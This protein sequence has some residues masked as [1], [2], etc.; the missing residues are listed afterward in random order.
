MRVKLTQDCTTT[1]GPA[2]AGSEIDH[3]DAGHL[4]RMKMAVAVDEEAV[5]F[6]KAL[7]LNTRG[8]PLPST[9]PGAAPPSPVSEVRPAPPPP[10]A[11]VKPKPDTPKPSP[12]KEEKEESSKKK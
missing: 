7:G 6:C 3:P 9:P 10:I 5:A 1:K 11:E 12:S 2:K 8:E 4:V